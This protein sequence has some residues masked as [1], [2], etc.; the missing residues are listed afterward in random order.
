MSYYTTQRPTVDDAEEIL[1]KYFP[2][3]D[4]GFVALK[5]YMGS[6]Q[7]IEE[8]ARVSYSYGIRKRGDTQAL[9]RSLMRRGHTSPFEM[10]EVKLHCAMPIF[11]ARQWI[12]HRTASVNEMSGR[13]SLMPMLFYKPTLEQVQAQSK[14]DKQGREGALP[15]KIAQAFIAGVE[16]SCDVH[17]DGYRWATENDIAREL[18]RIDLPLNIYTQWYW[19][20]D[21]NNLLK[22]L[23]QRCDLHAQWETRQYFNVIAGIAK[24]L[25]PLSFE[26]W[27]DYNFYAKKLSRQEMRVLRA[28]IKRKGDLLYSL[29]VDCHRRALEE[30]MSKTEVTEF[31]DK[32]EAEQRVSFDLDVASAKEPSFF[33]ELYRRS[34]EG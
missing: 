12:R 2:V 1:G 9:I 19:K 34:A 13:Y 5:D 21:G 29:P 11:V 16:N 6:D 22:A 23:S 3:H 25:M 27:E 20:I 18:A 15:D 4:A 32:F 8:S 7:C 28:L 33:E 14:K 24:R 17:G 10:V 30:L 31:L 26:A